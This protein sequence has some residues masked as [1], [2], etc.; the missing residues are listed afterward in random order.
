MSEVHRPIV[1]C[2][3]KWAMSNEQWSNATS[4][5]Q[6]APTKCNVQ[7]A[8]SNCNEQCSRCNVQRALV[9]RLVIP[10]AAQILF[11]D[12]WKIKG[13]D[14]FILT[15]LIFLGIIGQSLIL[16]FLLINP[17]SCLSNAMFSRQI[18]SVLIVHE[19]FTFQHTH[20]FCT[21][22]FL[23]ITSLASSMSIKR[24]ALAE[25]VPKTIGSPNW[26]ILD[27]SAVVAS[28][29][30][31]QSQTPA[32]ASTQWSKGNS[33]GIYIS[34]EDSAHKQYQNMKTNRN[35]YR[36]AYRRDSCM[37]GIGKC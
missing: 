19:K 27:S 1:M 36:K 14:L 31:H 25:K 9:H 2:N 30:E 20:P 24:D 35:M 32:Y 16:H 23:L 18:S 4:N 28:P 15:L 12:K 17:I 10:C 37:K 22:C 21:F 11:M 29:S 8:M 5:V 7:W 3:E 13:S 34:V 6:G 26:T 33:S